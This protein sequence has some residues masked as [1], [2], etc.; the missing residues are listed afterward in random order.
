MNQLREQNP[1]AYL[2]FWI[3]YQWRWNHP[4]FKIFH[5]FWHFPAWFRSWQ[6]FLEYFRWKTHL[7][8]EISI[9][10]ETCHN[11]FEQK[12][13]MGLLKSTPF[14]VLTLSQGV[15]TKQRCSCWWGLQNVQPLGCDRETELSSLKKKMYWSIVDLQCCVSFRCKTK[16][17]SYTD[18]YIPSFFSIFSHIGHYRVLIWVPRAIQ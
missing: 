12:K 5:A 16:W 13:K 6:Y 15:V 7:L 10:I 11:D 9:G 1:N 2:Y 3:K 18:T 14:P 8:K 17:I 4:L